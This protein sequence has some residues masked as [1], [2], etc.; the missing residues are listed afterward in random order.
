LTKIGKI[1]EKRVYEHFVDFARKSS[2]SEF[3]SIL[4]IFA[5]NRQKATLG[6]F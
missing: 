1:D 2:K 5:E 3:T 4:M 6:A